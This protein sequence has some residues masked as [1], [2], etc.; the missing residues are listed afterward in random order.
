MSSG[1]IERTQSIINAKYGR[2]TV[3]FWIKRSQLNAGVSETVRKKVKARDNHKCR[4]C[5]AIERIFIESGRE[6]PSNLYSCNDTV[7]HIISRR[8]IFWHILKSLDE[9]YDTVFC[10]EAVNELKT[11]MKEHHLF[12]QAEYLAYLC[13]TLDRVIQDA[14]EKEIFRKSMIISKPH[15]NNSFNPTPR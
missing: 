7:C 1:E 3:S 2:Q 4:I 8:S 6:P 13:K 15:P 9:K 5:A 14:L 10:D 11:K 12:S